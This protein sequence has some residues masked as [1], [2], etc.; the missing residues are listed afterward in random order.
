[1]KALPV[2]GYVKIAGMNPLRGRRRPRTWTARTARSPSWQRALVILAGPALAL[3]RRGAP[4]LAD[5]LLLVGDFRSTAPVVDASEATLNG[6]ASPA[7]AAGLQPGDVIVGSATSRTP[8]QDQM[9]E[10]VTGAVTD[11]PSSPIAVV[12]Q[13]DGQ[14]ARRSRSCRC[15][16]TVEGVTIG[17]VGI[18]SGTEP[19]SGLVPSVVGRGE[20][21]RLRDRGVDRADRPGLRAQGIGRIVTLLF[22]R[23]AARPERPDERRRHRPA[24][25]RDSASRATGGRCSTSSRSYASSSGLMN[26]DAAAA[27]R[28][29]APRGAR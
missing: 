16:T 8:T 24:G 11:H 5:L 20:G 14:D 3:P 2:G 29:R 27:L 6:C 25:R 26:L 28:R 18:V 23:R 9:R 22:T 15:S 12:V 19:A 4:V 17:R 13:R 10:L 1:M 21:G 7:A